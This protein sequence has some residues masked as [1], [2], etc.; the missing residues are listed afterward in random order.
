M[1]RN[2]MDR[3]G[4]MKMGAAT[5]AC[6]GLAFLAG[7]R[8]LFGGGRYVQFGTSLT[9]GAGTKLGGMIPSMAARQLGIEGIN[10]GCP[11]SCAGAH[12]YPAMDAVSLVALTNAIISGDW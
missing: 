2:P 6:S 8:S 1:L 4:L 7:R 11:G 5:A 9:A 3:R 12:K 10:A